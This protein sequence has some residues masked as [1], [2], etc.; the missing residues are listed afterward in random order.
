VLP[1][2]VQM[3]RGEDLEHKAEA[4]GRA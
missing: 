2:A 3:A 1:H 4:H